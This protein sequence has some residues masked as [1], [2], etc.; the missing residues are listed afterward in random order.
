MVIS[1]V[2]LM[3]F[4]NINREITINFKPITLLFGPN[5]SGKST[6]IQALH[7]AREVFE[8][9]NLDADVSSI[10]S[11]STQLG[12]FNYIL[13]NK[14]YSNKLKIG[15]GIDHSFYAPQKAVSNFDDT[16]FEALITQAHNI[17]VEVII[18][19]NSL[20]LTPMVEQY[21]VVLNNDKIIQI[22]FDLNLKKPMLSYFNSMHDI[23]NESI[24]KKPGVSFDEIYKL[25]RE[26]Y[27]SY[28]EYFSS[29]FKK[30]FNRCDLKYEYIL[31]D[32]LLEYALPNIYSRGHYLITNQEEDTLLSRKSPSNEGWKKLEIIGDLKNTDFENKMEVFESIILDSLLS[33]SRKM[34]S[35][36]LL[37]FLR[38]GP[39]RKVPD[40][41]RIHEK[42]SHENW[43]SGLSAYD[44]LYK[45]DSNFISNFNKVISGD[46]FFNFTYK[47]FIK[48][49][50]ELE[51]DNI[52]EDET[53]KISLEKY[54][55]YKRLVFIDD[56]TNQEIMP[57]DVG[58]GFSQVMPIIVASLKYQ[59]R[60][61]SIEQPE[62]HIHP[63]LQAQ[64]ADLFIHCVCNPDNQY[65]KFLIETHSEF[66]VLRV[67]KRINQI[68]KRHKPFS[69]D[70]IFDH[71]HLA[72][73][74]FDSNE[75]GIVISKIR[76][77]EDGDFLDRWPRGFFQE[78]MEE[79]F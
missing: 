48:K 78:R 49:Y 43:I 46:N 34:V 76:V 72:I 1:S 59:E 2:T 20:H 54:P 21:S 75:E 4:K 74:F 58:F 28:K 16:V 15:I 57:Q 22:N 17:Y 55:V 35:Y 3:N 30:H 42:P 65:G 77:D 47:A 73:Y 38:I 33:G 56:K 5:N 51:T 19:W 68:S 7:Y 14:N 64:L 44:I 27:L 66:I 32:S 40:R 52:S 45:S 41:L 50:I 60:L 8:N 36:F 26:R 6:I 23:F 37:K 71:T 39:F 25:N 13:R 9:G 18:S 69:S 79:L 63:S 62:L 11:N 70:N 10:N 31:N 24:C 67:L 29:L 61:I 53:S 12:G